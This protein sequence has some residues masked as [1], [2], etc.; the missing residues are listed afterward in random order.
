MKVSHGIILAGGTGS[1]LRPITDMFNKHMVPVYN[2]FIIDYSV[3]TAISTGIKNLTV[4]LG[5]P[6]YSQIVD[7]LKDGSQLGININY[8]LQLQP[9]G[10]AAAVN[11]CKNFINT[12]KFG[13]F[14]GDNLFENPVKF[15]ESSAGAQI[16]L[17]KHKELERFGVASIKGNKI[18]KIE[19]K[20]KVIDS[21]FNNYAVTGCYLFDNH[22]FEYFKELKPSARGEFEVSEIIEKY[23]NDGNL[24]YT[25][26]DG[27]W[28]DAGT[29]QS[30]N[31]LNNYFYNKENK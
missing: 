8:V 20:P 30:I 26:V 24:D 31:Y 19:E 6:H 2:K 12:D 5:G 15:K 18:I 9:N 22:F 7:Y 11:L 16:V 1:R 27:L 4:V 25:F 14:L 13:L 3:Q 29:H 23:N 28:H 10:I 21:N 17:T